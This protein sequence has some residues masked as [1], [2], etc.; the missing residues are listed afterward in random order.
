VIPLSWTLDHTAPMAKCVEDA[1]ILLKAIAGY[2]ERDP[3]TVDVPVPDYARA[4]KTPVSRLRLGIPRKPFFDE[5]DPEVAK[6]VLA[7]AYAYEQATEWHTRH[8]KL[9]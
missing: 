2:D 4:L 1:A 3:T 8:P 7:L 6:A 5:V 9:S